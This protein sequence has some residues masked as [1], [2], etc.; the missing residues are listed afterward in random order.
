M[1]VFR[2]KIW[3]LLIAL[4]Q[5]HLHLSEALVTKKLHLHFQFLKYEC[6]SFGAKGSMFLTWRC[7][8][9]CLQTTRLFP[10]KLYVSL[11]NQ[12]EEVWAIWR[13]SKAKL[14]RKQGSFWDKVLFSKVSPVHSICV[15]CCL[16]SFCWI[17]VVHLLLKQAQISPP[18]NPQR[19]FLWVR[20]GCQ[21]SQRK[22]PA[23]GEVWGTSGEVWGTSGE[24]WET[25]GEPLDCCYVP[26]WENYRGSRR[27][28]PGKF[29]E[30]PG[31][32]GDF[33]EARG[34]LTPYQRLA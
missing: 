9:K 22:G 25:S 24:V 3:Q 30:L 18:G 13:I 26:Q 2:F 32:S 5:L 6:N 15:S 16:P 11:V 28:L 33:S 7:P 19:K 31:N 4:L 1:T 17:I 14:S 27:K 34:I 21:A 12:Y 23:S 10:C 20:R 29:G 8:R